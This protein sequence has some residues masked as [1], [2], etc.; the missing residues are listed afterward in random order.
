MNDSCI[1]PVS[2]LI[3]SLVLTPSKYY[4]V[5]Y[6][7]M[8]DILLS[9][10]HQ[11]C[12]WWDDSDL[13]FNMSAVLQ[14]WMVL[15]YVDFVP[16]LSQKTEHVLAGSS[17]FHNILKTKHL[18]QKTKLISRKSTFKS[19]RKCRGLFNKEDNIDLDEEAQY[20]IKFPSITT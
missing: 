10:S 1:Q 16:A 6:D 9:S 7:Y 8:N 19:S 20:N 3:P 5:M 2:T 15:N 11:C 14:M 17:S 13:K 12:S 4:I 18:F